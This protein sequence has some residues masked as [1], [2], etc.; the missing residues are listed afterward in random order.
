MAQMDGM[1]GCGAEG[2]VLST[3]PA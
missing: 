2:E 3:L 1:G